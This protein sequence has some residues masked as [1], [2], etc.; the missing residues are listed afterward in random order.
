MN[1]ICRVCGT[2][3]KYDTIRSKYKRCAPCNSYY[4]LRYYYNNRAT[5]LE[6]N[7]KYYQD[8]KNYLQEYNRKRY[9]RIADLENQVKKL[10]E[11]INSTVTVS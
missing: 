3:K 2:E 1:N 5:Q 7:K 11:I 6:R 10:T 8:N 4:V 9:I